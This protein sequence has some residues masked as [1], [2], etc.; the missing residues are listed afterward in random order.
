MCLKKI[1]E[2]ISK[3]EEDMSRAIGIDISHHQD[4]FTNLGNLDFI[5]ARTSNGTRKD[6]KYLTFLP[7]IKK[8]ERRGTYHYYR[9]NLVEHPM[10]EQAE[11]FLGLS[12]GHGM[13]M[14]GID[15]ERSDYD[16]N[17]INQSTAL[18]L[19]GF[20]MYIMQNSPGKRVLLYTSIYTWRDV[21]LP[22]QGRDT[23]YGV[24]D[25][26]TFD[27]WLP[28]YGWADDTYIL[29]LSGIPIL[30][31]YDI[32]QASAGGNERGAEFGVGSL[33]VDYNEFPG[34][35]EEMDDWLDEKEPVPEPGDTYTQEE[36]DALLAEQSAKLSIACNLKVS[37]AYKDGW[38]EAVQEAVEVVE[39]IQK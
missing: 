3:K 8:T 20:C 15:Y 24:I 17:Q 5:I 39:A 21:L 28:R 16:D 23:E 31:R 37:L 10:Y 29:Q 12:E 22:M 14:I 38:N 2:W 27:I 32:W 11:L 9:T 33:H 26:Y 18:H 1:L 25:W 30:P 35:P 19:Y 36:V 34:T 6:T 13:R 7:E 4:T